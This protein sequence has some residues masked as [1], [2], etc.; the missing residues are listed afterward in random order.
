MKPPRNCYFCAGFVPPVPTPGFCVPGVC[1][2]V[3]G[4]D[5]PVCGCEGDVGPGSGPFSLMTA[6]FLRV[7]LL[8]IT[9]PDW[10]L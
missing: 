5:C 2:V 9:M 8:P 7:Y 6:F 3:D 4:C 1:G 10:P